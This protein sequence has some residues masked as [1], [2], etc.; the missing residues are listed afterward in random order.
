VVF[1]VEGGAGICEVWV[2]DG[3]APGTAVVASIPS[4]R[5][6]PFGIAPLGDGRVALTVGNAQGVGEL[7]VTDGTPAGT[8]LV[9]A[10]APGDLRADLALPGDM[11]GLGNGRAV[12]VAKASASGYEPWV[13]D[14]TAEGTALLR[15]VVPGAAGSWPTHLVA[16]DDGRALFVVHS[17]A[18]WVT[19]GTPAGTKPA[20]AGA[21]SVAEVV[22]LGAGR[23]VFTT[24]G[25]NG[26]ELWAT[27]G[28]AGGTRHLADVASPS[29]FTALGNGQAVFSAFGPHGGT[30]LWVTDGT[31]GG[32]EML[33]DVH[34]GP[35]H[36]RPREFA[37]FGDGRA[38][39]VAEDDLHGTALWF[40]DGTADGTRFLKDIHDHGVSNARVII[41]SAPVVGGA[42]APDAVF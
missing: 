41:A 22:S 36:G 16:L 5:G 6:Y 8:D 25:E 32:T 7:W 23:A 9:T 28:T 2:T 35:S 24:H 42:F 37:S 38:L 10:I 15:D 29:G 30:E 20:M 39:F 3:T 31:T 19:D 12:F 18:L 11:L 34:S 21:N 40:T 26:K 14:G 1:A 4:S 27:D 33:K 17:R 13:T